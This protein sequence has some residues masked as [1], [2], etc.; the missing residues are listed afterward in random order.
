M[1]I[2]L[3]LEVDVLQEEL[4]GE[5]QVLELIQALQNAVAPSINVN[6]SLEP[7]SVHV[8][9]VSIPSDADQPFNK[10]HIVENE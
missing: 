6:F 4:S 3:G 2:L 10:A 5:E 8:M 7:I 9:N 1:K